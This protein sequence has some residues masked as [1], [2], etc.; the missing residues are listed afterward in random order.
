MLYLYCMDKEMIRERYKELA[1]SD[2]LNDV[3][4]F[5]S[6]LKKL[7]S[8]SYVLYGEFLIKKGELKE[9]FDLLVDLLRE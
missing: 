1:K 4:L 2:K 8:G 9:L 7:R 6:P 3:R 5:M